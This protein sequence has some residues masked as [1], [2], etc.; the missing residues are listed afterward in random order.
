LGNLLEVINDTPRHCHHLILDDLAALLSDCKAIGC[1]ESTKVAVFTHVRVA[2]RLVNQAE[3]ITM[4]LL[5]G[6]ELIEEV[7]PYK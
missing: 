5:I 6:A 1:C 7:S 4:I 2:C 3:S